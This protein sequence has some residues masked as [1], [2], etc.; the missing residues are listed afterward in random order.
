M[1]GCNSH[2]GKINSSIVFMISV[3]V[4]E[5][6]YMIMWWKE[7]S[8]FQN[9][10]S[11]KNKVNNVRFYQTWMTL[12]EVSNHFFLVN[13]SL[14]NPA[15]NVEAYNSSSS[16]SSDHRNKEIRLEKWYDYFSILLG[17]VPMLDNK[18]TDNDLL[19]VL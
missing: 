9:N 6:F 2:F 5:S 15:K 3:T 11:E 12:P 17:K 1:G 7:S 10:V 19:T 4:T 16:I 8:N 13:K 14:K 18:Y